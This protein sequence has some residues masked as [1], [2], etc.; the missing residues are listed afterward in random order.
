MVGA[1]GLLMHYN[2]ASW[3][4]YVDIP[5]MPSGAF[6]RVEVKGNTIAAVGGVDNKGL[7]VI[8]RR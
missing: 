2:G 5:F 8:G 7:V 4:D 6:G 3:K 1:F